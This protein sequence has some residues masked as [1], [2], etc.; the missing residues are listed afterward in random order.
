MLRPGSALFI[1]VSSVVGIAGAGCKEKAG[2]AGG[3]GPAAKVAPG[4][5]PGEASTSARNRLHPHRGLLDEA[6]R[7]DLDDG[8]LVI[9]FGGIAQH[10]YTRGGWR[11]GWGDTHEGKDA[12]PQAWSEMTSRRAWLDIVVPEPAPATI[13][14]RA[15]SAVPGQKLTV[16]LGETA[17]TTL[18]VGADWTTARGA[19][20]EGAL[21]PG[22]QRLELRASQSASG[23]PRAEIDWLW[24]A[25]EGAPEE[26]VLVGRVGP[27]TLAGKVRRALIAPGPRS[28]TFYLQPGPGAHLVADLGAAAR[29]TFQVAV[30][31]DGAS[32]EVL[33]EHA[34]TEEGWVEKTV[35]LG[36]YAGKAIR[37]E[38]ITTAQEGAAGWGE[39]EILV[40]TAAPAPVAAG[41]RPRNVIFLVMDTARADSFAPYAAPDRKVQTPAFDALAKKSTVFTRA[42]NNENWTKPSVATSLS[43]LY[44]TT[45]DTKRDASELPKEVTLLPQ[46]LQAA[47]FATAGYVANGYISEKFGF[48]KGWDS[49]KNYIREGKNSEAAS[50]FGDAAA[51]LEKQRADKPDQPYF[52]YI[53]SIDPHVNYDVDREY[54]SRYYQGEYKGPL[55]PSISAEDQ[56]ALSK[57]KVPQSADNV[58]WLRALYWGE[59]TYHDDH[60]AKFLAK[61]E[62]L[63]ATKDTLLVIT[64]DHGEEL[65]ERGRFGHGHQIY[66]EMIRA[67]LLFSWDPMFSPGTEV[68]EIV[69]HVDLA[70]T[71]LD[72]LGAKP[73]EGSDGVSFLPLVQGKP[74][75][76]PRT[77]IV[78]FLDSWRAV[79]VGSFKLME[80]AGD[81]EKLFDVVA[82][83]AEAKDLADT[84][85]IALRLAQIHLGEGLGA[86]DKKA[87]KSG[88]AG[89]RRFRAGD[90]NIDPRMRRQLEALGYFG[91][92]PAA[93]TEDDPAPR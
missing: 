19:V 12:G 39:P 79:R 23:K 5:G 93:G 43:G 14:L 28:Y 31:A 45:H 74:D 25:R 46:H 53:Q 24:L 76:L 55:G 2:Q 61:L 32:R 91:S 37:L 59:V 85:P 51:W 1:I 78:E 82:D 35:P 4:E 40:E 16:Y 18:E 7:A 65:G 80:G 6:S 21:P 9:D 44:P 48:E 50:V 66:E 20:K 8:G 89:R 56:V 64:N 83:P 3:G 38:L 15:R 26:P 90:A 34:V 68:D 11:S 88:V 52:L 69:E 36:A 29:A 27:V 42:Y 63:G 57:E 60:L 49:F 67:P 84:A 54:W 47:G 41:A 13:A 22:P 33:L 62:E 81:K 58:G 86:P 72:V 10:K 30:T 75:Q 77:A 17:I 87:R 73:L 71:I 70:P 92:S